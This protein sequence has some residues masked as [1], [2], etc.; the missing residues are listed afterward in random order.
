M[1]TPQGC[2]TCFR[3]V[4]FLQIRRNNGGLNAIRKDQCSAD[5]N[6]LITQCHP[7]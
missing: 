7:K 1:L 2:P 4:K 3:Y 6:N 5:K